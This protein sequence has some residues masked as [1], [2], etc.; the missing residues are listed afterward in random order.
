M[1]HINVNVHICNTQY[2]HFWP[3]DV[4]GALPFKWKQCVFSQYDSRRQ[5]TITPFHKGPTQEY[6]SETRTLIHT[7]TLLFDQ[8]NGS[9]VKQI[10]L[11]VV[12][13][14]IVVLVLGC[15][16]LFVSVMMSP[17]S[18]HSWITPGLMLGSLV[19]WQ[20]EKS[21]LPFSTNWSEKCLHM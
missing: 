14:Q 19:G 9:K 3:Q 4:G 10:T 16:F 15:S 2:C 1:K 13:F 18:I 12:S 6:R 11:F 20:K 21:F 5:Q 8:S 7:H 17:G